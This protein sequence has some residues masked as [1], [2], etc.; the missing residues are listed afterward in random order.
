MVRSPASGSSCFGKLS[1]ESGQSLDPEPPDKMTGKIFAD[2]S[3]Y[4]RLRCSLR[5]QHTV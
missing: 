1:R 2:M 3:L 5:A 4:S